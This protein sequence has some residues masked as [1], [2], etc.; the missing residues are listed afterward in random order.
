MYK[1]QEKAYVIRTEYIILQATPSSSPTVYALRVLEAPEYGPVMNSLYGLPG[2]VPNVAYKSASL[3]GAKPGQTQTMFEVFPRMYTVKT[4]DEARQIASTYAGTGFNL[5]LSARNGDIAYACMSAVPRRKLGHTGMFPVIGDGSWDW[6]GVDAGADTIY[7]KNPQ[8]KFI[9]S[10]NS[11]I[12]PYG[13]PYHVGVDHPAPT[14]QGRITDLINAQLSSDG[15]VNKT[16][17]VAIQLDTRGNFWDSPTD[18]ASLRSLI[19]PGS[20]ANAILTASSPYVSQLQAM[21]AWDGMGR[22]GDQTTVIYEQLRVNFGALSRAYGL[23]TNTIRDY[24]TVKLVQ[25]NDT[26]CTLTPAFPGGPASFA[27]CT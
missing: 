26:I 3:D 5:G 18:G 10:A 23:S 15:V 14:R 6:N 21:L 2:N 7:T 16:D 24:T 22:I 8:K 11:H 19:A 9:V 17:A 1:G 27:N 25:A 13:F 12:V 20:D 4:V